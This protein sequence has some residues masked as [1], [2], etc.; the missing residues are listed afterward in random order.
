MA[1]DTSISAKKKEQIQ[2]IEA[3]DDQLTT[4]SC[5]SLFAIYLRSI[6]LFPIIERLFGKLRKSIIRVKASQSNH[7]LPL[8]CFIFCIHRLRSRDER[9]LSGHNVE[10]CGADFCVRNSDW[11]A[12]FQNRIWY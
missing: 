12:V 11:L 6:Q 7:L 3:T 2:A 9:E 10:L 8:E 1:K 4:R 5:L